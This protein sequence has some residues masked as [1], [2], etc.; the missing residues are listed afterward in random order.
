MFERLNKSTDIL[1]EVLSI[2]QHDIHG[3]GFLN[4]TTIKQQIK[5]VKEGTDVKLKKKGESKKNKFVCHNCKKPGHI[6]TYCNKLSLD[7]AKS[8]GPSML[9]Q[10]QSD[11][12]C[13]V[14]YTY[15]KTNI[16]GS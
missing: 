16:S 1:N 12:N 10:Q 5:F 13:M 7:Y 3:L 14:V 15:L 8:K 11:L 9:T 4:E 6:R 2:G